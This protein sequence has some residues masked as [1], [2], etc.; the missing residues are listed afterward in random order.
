MSKSKA[1]LFENATAEFK[2]YEEKMLELSKKQLFDSAYQIHAKNEIYGYLCD[3]AIEDLKS[4]EIDVLLGLGDN[5]IKTLYGFYLSV[6][7]ASI[8]YYSHITE[9]VR[10]FCKGMIEDEI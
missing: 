3:C 8:M 1:V 2:V 6:D 4:E 7:N 5:V 10:D 9:W